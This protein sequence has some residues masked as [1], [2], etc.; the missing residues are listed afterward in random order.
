MMI[1]FMLIFVCIVSLIGCAGLLAIDRELGGPACTKVP[2]NKK[3]CV[4]TEKKK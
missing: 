2:P 1:F 4:F 3:V